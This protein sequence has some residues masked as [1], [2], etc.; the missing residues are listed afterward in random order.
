MSLANCLNV[1]C[2]KIAKAEKRLGLKSSNLLTETILKNFSSYITQL[3]CRIARLEK[4]LNLR[5][6]SKALP[7]QTDSIEILVGKLNLRTDRVLR[8]LRRRQIPIPIQI[9]CLIFIVG[10]NA[11]DTTGI[12]TVYT[13]ATANGINL[14]RPAGAVFFGTSVAI[15]ADCQTAIVGDFNGDGGDGITTI[16]TS[17]NNWTDVGIN[18]MRPAGASA[19]GFTVSISGD[20]Q[21]AIVGDSNGTVTIFTSAN[22]WGNAGIDLMIPA[23][24][25]QFGSSVAISEDGETAIVGDVDGGGD[26]DGAA[27]VYTS[28]NNWTDAGISV[29]RPA[30]AAEFGQSVSISGD[31]QTAIVGDPSGGGDSDGAATIFT[32]ANNWTDAGVSVMRP[33]NAGA[34]GRGVSILADGETAIV[35]DPTGAADNDGAATIFTSANNW[36]NAGI[37]LMRPAGASAFGQSVSISTVGPTALV[38]D[39]NGGGDNDGAA[40][41][42]TS[43]NNWTNAGINL[44]R[45][46]GAVDFGGSV[47]IGSSIS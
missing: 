31:G 30:G 42:Y 7:A 47:G 27:T 2:Q 25:S 45:P 5:T 23:G 17:A 8:I 24:A 28:A 3:S 37:N 1:L 18:L 29:V 43:E 39:F 19:F 33:A 20:G 40:T 41:V 11:G 46:A 13:S 35:G 12:A 6:R 36:T 14:V 34:F 9:S 38:G 44:I 22:N 16:F 10:D 26:N 21:T 15:S 4:I 32:S